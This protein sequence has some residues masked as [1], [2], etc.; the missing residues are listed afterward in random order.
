MFKNF[1]ILNSHGVKIDCMSTRRLEPFSWFISLTSRDDQQCQVEREIHAISVCFV[2]FWNLNVMCKNLFRS[3]RNIAEH[4]SI[5][6]FQIYVSRFIFICWTPK[7]FTFE[8]LLLLSCLSINWWWNFRM[9]ES[10]GFLIKYWVVTWVFHLHFNPFLFFF[11][12]R[13]HHEFW[14]N[15]DK[16]YMM[17]SWM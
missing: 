5:F 15:F 7:S 4:I 1:F 17:I 2:L 3:K 14:E 13:L 11:N 12:S 6:R 9:K 16:K 8:F 10:C